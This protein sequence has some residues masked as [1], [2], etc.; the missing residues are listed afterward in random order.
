MTDLT[1]SEGTR[2]ITIEHEERGYQD[3]ND[4]GMEVLEAF[5]SDLNSKEV[6]NSCGNEVGCKNFYC[7]VC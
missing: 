5:T 4:G 7:Y 2:T 6:C 3:D 1:K